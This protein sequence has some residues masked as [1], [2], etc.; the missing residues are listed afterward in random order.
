V[1]QEDTRAAAEARILQEAFEAAGQAVFDAMADLFPSR[2]C[3]M[4]ARD[5]ATGLLASLERKNCVTIAE[6]AGHA[7]PD[8]LHYLL[9]RAVW[10]ERELRAR[11]GALAIERLGGDGVLIFDETGD[12]KKGRSSLGA[13]RQYTGTAG[14]V[15]NAQVTTWA[16][17]ATSAGHALIDFEVYLHKEWFAED[18]GRLGAS[19]A[20]G[21]VAKRTKGQQAAE[22]LRRLGAGPARP[23]AV[24]ATGD[25]VYGAS[26]H[27]RRGL[28]DARLPFVLACAS[29][30]KLRT[31]PL[32]DPARADELAE[33]IPTLN[34]QIHA[35][36]KGAKGL[37]EYSW[38]WLDLTV[39]EEPTGHHY[40]LVR[41]NLTSG[42]QAFYRCWSPEPRSLHDLAA[43]AGA[44][45]A[46]EESFQQA[47]G[48]VGLD[49]HQVRTWEATHRHLTLAMAA[50]LVI[51]LTTIAARVEFP[52]DDELDKL[53]LPETA[54]LIAALVLTIQHTATHILAWSRWRR[55]RNKA[56]RRSH[57]RR[58]D[59]PEPRT[60]THTENV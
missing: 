29:S 38:G 2:P 15:E 47:K 42:E 48:R 16:V 52:E 22:M 7:S 1:R 32:I 11:I 18:D 55:R 34:W 40:L 26:P 9:E 56:A 46:I 24:S 20:P 45:W 8:R 30:T 39:A 6:W 28:Y 4:S 57:Y 44:R 3:R 33:S 27:L 19:H 17:W 49:H 14:R 37:R 10:E 54:H 43:L 58:R 53:T 41:Q 35:V 23:S 60:T 21:P 12:L 25:E 5:Y 50:Y 36:G 59:H 51:T 13:A 31:D